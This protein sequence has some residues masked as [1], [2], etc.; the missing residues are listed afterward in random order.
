MLDTTSDNML[1]P[2]NQTAAAAT[3]MV[4]GDD[5]MH[6]MKYS[7]MPPSRYAAK[8]LT[9]DMAVNPPAHFGL[10]NW[11][12]LFQHSNNLAQYKGAPYT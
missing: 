3:A 9:K 2:P 10:H 5:D 1:S 7:T 11:K 8:K 6:H 12:W 4:S